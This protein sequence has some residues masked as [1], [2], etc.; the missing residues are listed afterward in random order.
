VGAA[1]LYFTELAERGA[2]RDKVL[3]GA[4]PVKDT[5]NVLAGF[6]DEEIA[7]DL[8]DLIGPPQP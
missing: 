5:E 4:R 3:A 7:T 8:A 1:R 2:A 6:S